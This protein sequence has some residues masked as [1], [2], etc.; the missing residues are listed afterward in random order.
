M[1]NN[2]TTLSLLLL[3]LSMAALLILNPPTTV[4]AEK[5]VPVEAESKP[6]TK[7]PEPFNAM[8]EFCN[9]K[10]NK[11]DREFCNRVLKS[12][13]RSASA[14]DNVGLLLIS[15]DLAIGKTNKTREYYI[16]SWAKLIH[17]KKPSN[18]EALISALKDCV[19]AYEWGIGELKIIP[20]E[21]KDDPPTASYDALMAHDA[22]QTCDDSL[23]KNKISNYPVLIRH[24]SSARY[25]Q[26]CVDI[27][28]TVG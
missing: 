23:S 17:H 19:H 6:T 22:L 20:A 26:L 11:R 21:L 10:A 25:V 27:S 8:N 5:H 7:K 12:D 15:V 4:I 24:R 14:K 3:L 1:T 9:Q 16:Y 28:M 18:S 13:P 2:S